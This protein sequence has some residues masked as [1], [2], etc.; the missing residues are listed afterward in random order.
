MRRISNDEFELLK[1]EASRLTKP[2]NE[3]R[4]NDYITALV[5]TVLDKQL[6]RV[7]IQ[8]AEDHFAT[9][10]KIKTL[11]DLVKLM[12]NF[13]DDTTGNTQLARVL[14]NYD[15]WNRAQD[16]RR[17]TRYYEE[18]QVT[19]LESLKLWAHTSDYER[20]FH[21]QIPNLAYA[22]YQWIRIRMG[23]NTVKPDSRLRKWVEDRVGWIPNDKELVRVMQR[24]AR[25]IGWRADHL[26]W[27]IWDQQ[28]HNPHVP[29]RQMIRPSRNHLMFGR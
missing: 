6:H 18:R 19:D 25:E 4:D 23:V 12:E 22:S 29:C 10:V 1:A 20:D 16:L 11:R 7:T 2:E 26:D 27:A 21:K 3:Y 28:E 15:Y 14:W 24:V 8:R 5:N 13:S 9:C 17:L